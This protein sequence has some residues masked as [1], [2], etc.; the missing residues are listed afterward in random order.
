MTCSSFILKNHFL[1][2]ILFPRVLSVFQFPFDFLTSYYYFPTLCDRSA[3]NSYNN[4]MNVAD[5]LSTYLA[6]WYSQVLAMPFDKCQAPLDYC[7]ICNLIF[8]FVA[9]SQKN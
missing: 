9:S 4:G 7:T 6:T 1:E 2:M 8:P 5:W 3:K